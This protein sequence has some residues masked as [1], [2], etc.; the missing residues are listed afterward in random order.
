MPKAQRSLALKADACGFHWVWDDGWR[1][2]PP[3]TKQT[4]VDAGGDSQIKLVW[5]RGYR[6]KFDSEYDWIEYVP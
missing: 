3:D 1:P 2:K 4:W 5:V 6:P